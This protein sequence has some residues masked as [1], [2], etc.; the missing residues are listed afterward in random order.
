MD[1]L[2]IS[3]TKIKIMLTSDDV[4]NFG[5]NIDN[6]DYSDKATRSKVW[7]IL[8]YVKANHNFNH[9]GD[10]L[11]IQFYPSRDGGAELF[12]TKIS[13]LPTGSERAISKTGN[14]TML[15][16]KKTIYNF[17]EFEDLIRA[18][19]ILKST[20][21]IRESELFF[22]EAEGYYLE[23]TE[24]GSSRLGLICE[25]AFLLEFAKNTPIEK[26]PYILEHCK[27]LTNGKAV[28]QLAR[29]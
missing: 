16:S 7:E 11:L 20:K 17:K 13:K 24:R 26:Y 18:V 1:V 21:C 6:V 14:V 4:K 3:N 23:L 10:K 8:D 22:D 25:F 9:G 27:K 15:N 29:L 5:L 12:V 28:E 19:K 2:T